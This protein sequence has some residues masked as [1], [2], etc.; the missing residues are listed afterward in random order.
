WRGRFEIGRRAAAERQ[1]EQQSRA[2]APE[3]TERSWQYRLHAVARN[4]VN[5]SAANKKPAAGEFLAQSGLPVYLCLLGTAP[6][7]PRA[8]A[9]QRLASA[10]AKRRVSR[11]AP[12]NSM[13]PP[14][15][16][17]EFPPPLICINSNV[18][19]CR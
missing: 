15:A 3:A 9:M 13:Q 10:T 16:D 14:V 12:Q 17:A 1:Q 8:V 6:P 18:S 19:T 11:S 2:D 5:P 4:S 7:R